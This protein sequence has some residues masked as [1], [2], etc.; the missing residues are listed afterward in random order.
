MISCIMAWNIS[1]GRF[2]RSFGKNSSKYCSASPNC[3]RAA[4]S[5]SNA[6]FCASNLASS[7]NNEFKLAIALLS[8]ALDLAIFS[9]WAGD[10]CSRVSRPLA[11]SCCAS[12]SASPFSFSCFSMSSWIRLFKSA[13]FASFSTISSCFSIRPLA[14]TEATPSS[15]S[16]A[17][18]IVSS[19]NSD[20]SSMSIP[21]ISTLATTTGSISGLICSKIGVPTSS[22]NIADTISMLPDNSI[23]ALS[24]LVSC[25]YS[26]MII[27]EFSLDTELMFLRPL[28]VLKTASKGLVTICSTFSG[29]A[30]GYV[31]TT[32]I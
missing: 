24:I 13:I 20:N 10:S 22:S 32:T 1:E 30:P 15:L 26:S 5:F 28:E 29:L 17:G 23:M 7:A 4:F 21:S 19:V 16:K 25:K 6:S 31:V 8:S 12:L 11:I 27:L 18:T 14:L 2:L 9:F 3:S